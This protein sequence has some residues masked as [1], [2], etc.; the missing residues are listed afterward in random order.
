MSNAGNTLKTLM[1]ALYYP[2]VLGTALVLFINKLAI[3][4]DFFSA[5]T[6]ITNY[7]AFTLILFFSVS[8]LVNDSIPSG[9]YRPLTFTLDIIEIVII[10]LGF[11][12]L[13]FL[14]PQTPNKVNFQGFYLCG[15]FLLILQQIW[16][17]TIG[18]YNKTFWILSVVAAIIMI[19]GGFLAERWFFIN[20]F[21]MVLLLGLL[22]TYLVVLLKDN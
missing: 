2:A 18:Y 5:L 4:Q 3:Q 11:S 21:I 14:D 6:D 20:I 7:Y 15:A 19:I 16:N 8:Y 13:G 10:F 12:F 22:S 9:S 17:A 1:Q